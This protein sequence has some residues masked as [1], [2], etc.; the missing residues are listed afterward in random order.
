MCAPSAAYMTSVTRFAA[1]S[2]GTRSS[3]GGTTGSRARSVQTTSP[4]SAASPSTR[5][6]N[7]ASNPRS[8]TSTIA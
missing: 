1:A 6:G 8:R 5:N 7:T 2:P 3:D 4:A